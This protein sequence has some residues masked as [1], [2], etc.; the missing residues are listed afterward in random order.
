MDKKRLKRAIE[1]VLTVFSFLLFVSVLVTTSFAAEDSVVKYEKYLET[2]PK[3]A[4]R[5]ST[6]LSEIADNNLVSEFF[7]ISDALFAE[8]FE[9]GLLPSEYETIERMPSEEDLASAPKVSAKDLLAT[10][11]RLYGEG[12]STRIK[13]DTTFTSMHLRLVYRASE[14]AYAFCSAIFQ[15]YEV[16]PHYSNLIR[17]EIVGED[18]ILYSA[19]TEWSYPEPNQAGKN[20]FVL[21]D[22][23]GYSLSR[24]TVVGG[25]SPAIGSF[26]YADAVEMESIMENLEAGKADEYLPVYKH[27]FK[28]NV[29]GSYYWAR[30]D[31]VS[32]GKP[33][34]SSVLGAKISS[35]VIRTLPA[36]V[37]LAAY[38]GGEETASSMALDGSAVRIL[39][40][41]LK[42]RSLLPDTIRVLE[43]SPTEEDKLAAPK[44]SAAY[45]SEIMES[46]FGTGAADLLKGKTVLS[47]GQEYLYLLEDGKTYAYVSHGAALDSEASARRI[48]FVRSEQVGEDLAVYVRY[49]RYAPFVPGEGR[50]LW[51]YGAEEGAENAACL[52]EK[53]DVSD[54]G[55]NI[56]TKI[57]SGKLDDYFPVYKHTFKSN[58]DGTYA[59]IKTELDTAGKEIPPSV[60]SASSVP[61]ETP[62][63]PATDT[64]APTD[65][66]AEEASFPWVW[67][68]IG[69]A[70][71]IVA[72]GAI[73]FFKKKKI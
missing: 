38:T 45:L 12:A 55:S 54:L 22:V 10:I 19:Y 61:E 41:A 58:G 31:L 60:L 21:Y 8:L 65:G 63:N 4:Y 62:G 37:P 29:D 6:S 35:D 59:W 44:V 5:G 64:S 53:T 2:V 48:Q 32:E 56:W 25:A 26:E 68:G 24:Q 73:L 36:K 52:M 51:F 11:D 14:D 1:T 23:S 43:Q 27:V 20:N 30:T 46:L 42:E 3:D 50:E 34:P 16:I 67:V 17:S 66:A 69:G 33:I 70:A 28:K 57:E 39:I 7:G 49:A 9:Q 13:K 71:V 72:I 40:D 47:S 18:L 15:S